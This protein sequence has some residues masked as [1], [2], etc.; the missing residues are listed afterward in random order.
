MFVVHG[1]M[2]LTALLL[3]LV[4]GPLC[5]MILGFSWFLA[6]LGV[7]YRDINQFIA[8]F[9]TALLFLSPVF[10]PLSA[11]PGWLRPWVAL[12]PMALPVEAAR[13]VLI[14]GTAPNFADLAVYA[15]V[16]LCIAASGYA[17]FQKTRKGF[18]DVL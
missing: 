11:L 2:P 6:S 5:V 17:W 14:F 13:A 1:R 10:L 8:T 9:V 18:A 12:N 16:G 3:P 4:L 15:A 7:Y